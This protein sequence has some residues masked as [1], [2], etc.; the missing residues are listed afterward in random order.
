MLK[1]NP[2]IVRGVSK[3]CR[4]ADTNL[5]LLGK[6]FKESCSKLRKHANKTLGGFKVFISRYLVIHFKHVHPC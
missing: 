2:D 3:L 1:K 6:S 4:Y 5:P